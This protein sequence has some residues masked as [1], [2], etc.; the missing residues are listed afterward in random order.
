MTKKITRTMQALALGLMALC[1][2]IPTA[3]AQYQ[4]DWVASYNGVPPT[5]GWEPSDWVNDM[6]VRDGYI[7][8]TGY[9]SAATAYWATV[10]YDYTGQEIWVRDT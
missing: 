5:S 4:Q 10:K 1:L 8:V 2:A 9:E 6:V 7:Y 3:N